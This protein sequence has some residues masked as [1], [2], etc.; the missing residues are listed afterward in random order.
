MFKIYTLINENVYAERG[1]SRDILIKLLDF[2]KRIKIIG[3]LG[4]KI[5]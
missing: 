3:S 4:N 5:I 1:T 2:K